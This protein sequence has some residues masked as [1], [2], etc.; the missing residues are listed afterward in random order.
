MRACLGQLEH[1]TSLCKLKRD[2][3]L[4]LPE[5][6]DM[7]SLTLKTFPRSR[8]KI[9][10]DNGKTGTLHLLKAEQPVDKARSEQSES[11]G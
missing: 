9:W 8:W 6:V 7:V 5:R 1:S 3:R 10:C 2:L 4:P 11:E